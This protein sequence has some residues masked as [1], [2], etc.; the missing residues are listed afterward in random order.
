LP[1][2]KGALREAECT[3]LC[4]VLRSTDIWRGGSYNA[5]MT[6]FRAPSG[7][8]EALRHAVELVNRDL[9]GLLDDLDTHQQYQFW[10]NLHQYAL[11]QS[12]HKR[13]RPHLIASAEAVDAAAREALELADEKFAEH[14]DPL[15]GMDRDRFWRMLHETAEQQAEMTGHTKAGFGGGKH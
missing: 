11:A 5:R 7:A 9:E 15:S 8:S 3:G 12:E 10:S 4:S 13:Q 6:T 2:R 14:L 1:Q